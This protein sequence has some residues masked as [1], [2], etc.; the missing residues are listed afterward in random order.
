ME[1]NYTEEALINRI[2]TEITNQIRPRS[3]YPSTLGEILK[4]IVKI[5]GECV[6]GTQ[7]PRGERGLQYWPVYDSIYYGYDGNSAKLNDIK[8]LLNY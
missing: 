7:G 5:K 6:V 1:T 3:I 4:G 8:Q 2:K